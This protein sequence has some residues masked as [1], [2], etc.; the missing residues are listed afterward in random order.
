MG[1]FKGKQ[2]PGGQVTHALPPKPF[3]AALKRAIIQNNG[4]HLRAMADKVLDLAAAGEP[5]ACIF[6]ADRLD[7][8]PKQR[9]E[10]EDGDGKPL[11]VRA[12]SFV[13]VDGPAKNVID[14]TPTSQQPAALKPVQR[15][16]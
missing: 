4:K 13:V 3:E 7:G 2:N 6:V 14:V 10:A 8:K 12:I 9:I 16:A 5:W 1:T 15:A 11:P